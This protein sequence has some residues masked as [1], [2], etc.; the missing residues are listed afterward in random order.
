ML[1]CRR[2][3]HNIG[4]KWHAVCLLHGNLPASHWANPYDIRH[5][6]S[7]RLTLMPDRIPMAIA[8]FTIQQTNTNKFKHHIRTTH[9]C[10]K[11]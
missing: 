10:Q 6:L 7:R 3:Q 2:Q 8:H 11:Y 5:T 4:M 1:T 9:F